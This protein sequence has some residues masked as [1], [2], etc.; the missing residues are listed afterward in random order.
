M[1]TGNIIQEAP[2]AGL[3]EPAPEGAGYRD[4]GDHQEDGH[5]HRNHRNRLAGAIKTSAGNDGDCLRLRSN[6]CRNVI[7]LS[8]VPEVH[9]HS[10]E[11]CL[12]NV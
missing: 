1:Q 2:L 11:L 5:K 10:L 3:G 8:E 6:R 7:R 4:G 9:L 12:A